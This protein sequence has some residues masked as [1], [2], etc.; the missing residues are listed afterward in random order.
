MLVLVTVGTP[1]SAT[2]D[3]LVREI[4]RRIVAGVAPAR[5]VLFGS[6]ARDGG[7]AASDFDLLVVWNDDD[8]PPFRAAAVRRCLRGVGA[9]FDI[10]V[11]TPSEFDRLRRIP[12]HI[13][14]E[15]V[16]TG[17]VVHAA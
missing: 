16:E 17:R 1:A 12:W 6:R 7:A 8:P 2:E 15:A 9:A 5:I 3:A 14:H 10:A 11:V 4:V 13:V